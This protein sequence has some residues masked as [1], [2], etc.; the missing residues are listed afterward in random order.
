MPKAKKKK[1]VILPMECIGVYL[2][3]AG[4]KEVT[5]EHLIQVAPMVLT[6]RMRRMPFDTTDGLPKDWENILNG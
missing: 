3:A 6:H 4:A 2:E 1:L 5:R